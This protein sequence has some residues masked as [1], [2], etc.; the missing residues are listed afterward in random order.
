MELSDEE[1][2]Y[3]RSVGTV[4]EQR[5]DFAPEGYHIFA[6]NGDCGNLD[7][8]TEFPT[9]KVHEEGVRP[10][11]CEAFTAQSLGCISFRARGGLVARIR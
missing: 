2:E 8:T 3:L 1:A 10:R 7:R 6:L 4:L 11:V 5:D 9:C